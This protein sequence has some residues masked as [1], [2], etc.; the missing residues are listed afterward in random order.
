MDGIVKS[1][2]EDEGFG[3]ISTEG[4][5]DIWVHYSD[6]TPDPVRFPNG[7]R[8]LK[9]GQHVSFD[10]MMNPLLKEQSKKAVKVIIK[11]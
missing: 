8:S 2:I 9:I 7:Y 4:Q 11:I 1:W 6:I 5:D 10:L 3:W